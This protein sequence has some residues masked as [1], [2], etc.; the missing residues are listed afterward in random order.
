MKRFASSF[1]YC[2]AFSCKIKEIFSANEHFFAENFCPAH[3]GPEQA[4]QSAQRIHPEVP[5]RAQ[6]C[7]KKTEKQDCAAQRP[8]QNIA[9]QNALR[10]MPTVL[11]GDFNA[12]PDAP[13]IVKISTGGI[14]TD[15]TAD[16][17]GTFH[18]FG[19]LNESAKID[20][21]FVTDDIKCTAAFAV[22]EIR[23]GLYLS[24]HDP[25]VADITVH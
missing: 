1:H 19:R 12:T 6:Q 10:P 9:S 2:I 7:G 16:I 22:H 21:V 24:D 13:E 8:Q 15:V 14:F 17:K 18:D 4:Q 23:D 20:Y 11:T 3:R 25:V 5:Q